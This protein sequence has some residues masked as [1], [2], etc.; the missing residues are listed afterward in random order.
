M[1]AFCEWNFY[2]HSVKNLSEMRKIISFFFSL[3]YWSSFQHGSRLKLCLSVPDKRKVWEM[4]M[5]RD[6]PL[7]RKNEKHFPWL[8][9][10]KSN[11]NEK[12]F[13]VKRNYKVHLLNSNPG[14]NILSNDCLSSLQ[15]NHYKG[16]F[17][18]SVL[19]L[20]YQILQRP[21]TDVRF[22]LFGFKKS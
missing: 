11:L 18:E 17:Q 3:I 10:W 8:P 7:F 21:T 1:K 2:F 19:L 5:I 4:S 14:F 22:W 20:S 16:W 6:R 9:W 13:S 12:Y 15:K